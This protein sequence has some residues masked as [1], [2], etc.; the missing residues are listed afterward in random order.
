[1]THL[2]RFMS[3]IEGQFDNQRQWAIK[4]DP[5]FPKA[6]H[7]NTNC[8]SKIL[9]IPQHFKGQFLLEEN[10]YTLHD[11]TRRSAHLFSFTEEDDKI[12]LLSYQVPKTVDKHPVVT[13]EELPEI[14]FEDLQPSK[15]FS[16]A[17]FEEI[18]PNVWKTHSVSK[19]GKDRQFILNETFTNHQ[20]IVNEKM[21]KGDKITFGFDEPII[22]DR[23]S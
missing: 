20:L 13:Y 14:D 1:M 16:V 5:A 6:R 19:S 15:Q 11:K 18:E 21:M 12:Q 17:Y 23:L 4:K 2:E 3:M 7:I 10:D 22:Y 8:T 9:N